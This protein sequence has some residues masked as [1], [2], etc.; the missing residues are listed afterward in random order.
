MPCRVRFNGRVRRILLIAVL[1]VTAL[2]G[3][4]PTNVAGPTPTATSGTQSPTPSASAEPTATPTAEP[5]ATPVGFACE[6]VVTAQEM[7]DFNSIYSQTDSAPAAGTLA[8]RAV[9]LGGIACTWV[10]T[11]SGSTIVFGFAQA[12]PADAGQSFELVDG[13]GVAQTVV[14][15]YWVSVASADLTSEQDA[16]PLLDIATNSLR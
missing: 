4:V 6:D 16:A 5:G 7:Y 13:V 9:E 14:G 10:N 11:S 8:A 15:P 3:C 12:A 2:A 1:A